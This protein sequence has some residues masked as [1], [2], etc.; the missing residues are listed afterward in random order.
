MADTDEINL[1]HLHMDIDH[2][3]RQQRTAQVIEALK[4]KEKRASIAARLGTSPAYITRIAKAA[5]FMS[6]YR[7]TRKNEPEIIKAYT[8][9]VPVKDIIEKF[10]IDRKTL[11]NMVRR[12]GTPLRQPHSSSIERAAAERFFSRRASTEHDDPQPEAP[13]G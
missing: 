6:P 13:T 3:R 10:E 12:T 7:Q 11:W 9:D 5:G 2:Y 4:N 8:D 1:P